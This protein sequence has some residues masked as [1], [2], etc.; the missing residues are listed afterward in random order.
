MIDL[1][2]Y[3]K[4]KICDIISMWNEDNIYAISFF[5]YSNEAYQYNGYSNVTEF[6]V[7]YNTEADC[8]GADRFSEERWNYA[9]WRQNE[10]PVIEANNENEGIKILFEWYKQNSIVNIG[11]EDSKACYDDKMRYIGKGPV[12]YYELLSEI[13][14]VA[15]ELQDS[16]FIKNKFGRAIPIILHDLEYAWYVM[17]ATKKANPNGEA[18]VFFAAMKKLGFNTGD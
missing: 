1:Q 10:F 18:D 8:N 11:Y 13:A 5:V 15:K 12:G 17:E 4:S 7:S 6:C 2:T 14:I 9:F 3:L 16:G